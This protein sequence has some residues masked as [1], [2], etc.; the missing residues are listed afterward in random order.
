MLGELFDPKA[1]WFVHEHFRPHWSQAGAVVFITFRT[2]DSIPHEVLLQWERE[3]QEW[4][5][6]RGH[7]AGMHWS[8][9]VPTLTE[10]ERADF[11]EE[12]Q[13]RREVCLDACHG[14]CLLRRPDLARIVADS[15]LHFD[16]E[17][18]RLGDFIIMPTHV[19]LLAAF[20]TAEAM[21][22]QCDSWLHYT[23]FQINR[24]IGEKGK[25]W[26]QEPFDHLVRSLE[27]YEYLRQYIADNPRK[28][29]LKSGEYLYRRYDG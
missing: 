17:R 3:K 9:V 28:A 2:H 8:L 11:Q 25:F 24:T 7:D 14:R 20:S 15:L 5:R 13:R 10:K 4:L 27:Q 16:S 21:K 1:E 18:Y 6:L 12:F 29:V 22:N 23:A 19:H 26:Q